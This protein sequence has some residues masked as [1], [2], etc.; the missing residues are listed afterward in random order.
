MHGFMNVMAK[1]YVVYS[2]LYF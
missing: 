2:I 1:Y